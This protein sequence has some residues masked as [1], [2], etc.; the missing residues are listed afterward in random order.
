MD[1]ISDRRKNIIMGAIIVSMF[2]CS[3]NQ[4]IIG[5]AMPRIIANLG[6]MEYYSWIITSYLLTLT[7][8]AALVG[9]LS[10]I[11]G[12]KY[13][14]LGGII[15]FIIGA[16]L[17]G[18][19]KDA[20]QLILYRG[21]QGIGAGIVM[22]TNSAAIGDLFSPRERG[23][24]IG[25]NNAF[26]GVS[27][28]LGPSFGGYIVDHFKW[29]WVFWVFLPIGFVAFFMILSLYPK[30][31]RQKSQSIDYPGSLLLT[32]T[33]V[34]ILL[35]FSWAGTKYPWSSSAI[36]GL[37]AVTTVVLG[38]FIFTETKVK[39]PIIPLG[40]FKSRVFTV[41]NI[42]CFIMSASMTCAGIYMPLFVQ[43]VM[44]I[45]P[46]FA[47]Y[48]MMPQSVGMLVM[49]AY[50]GQRMTKTGKYKKLA[51]IGI[52][53][54]TGGMF[55]MVIMGNISVAVIG[56]I[57]LGF[58]FGLAMP[59]FTLAIQ[60][61]VDYRDLGV[62]I[63]SNLLFRNLGGTIG[64]AVM[65][66]IFS[67]SLGNKMNGL[68]SASGGIHSYGLDPEVANRLTHLLSPE[69]LLDRS[70]IS[71]VH[72]SL[73]ASTQPAFDSL[74]E[75]LTQALAGSLANVFLAGTIILVFAFLLTFFLEELSL[76][77]TD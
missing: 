41:S 69:L 65:G 5:V 52:A 55:L 76:R 24:W 46:T 34:S 66:A 2:F 9:K 47:G 33:I 60:N 51:L 6:G 64:I 26:M 10:D 14:I 3:I 8:A 15:V 68:I 53:S 77:S 22:P 31:E 42:L 67:T 32:I 11:Y 75:L 7:I 39:T 16:F 48:V 63:S 37:F 17:A 1:H 73:P 49:S 54:M 61:V 25:F 20:I 58:G 40:L 13:F 56:M 62:A 71:D 50:A 45:S 23:R 74:L 18:T 19:S 35:A 21:I 4:T 28:I 27:T 30:A 44:E 12:R 36:I 43:G 29:N 57:I 72:N 59:V 70:Q 38:A